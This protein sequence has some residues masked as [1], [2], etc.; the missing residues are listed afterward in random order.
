M[1]R[2]VVLIPAFL[3]LLAIGAGTDAQQGAPFNPHGN[4][5]TATNN[6]MA[7]HQPHAQN[8]S[9]EA[10][11]SSCHPVIQTHESQSCAACHD[12]HAQTTNAALVRLT[13]RGKPVVFDGKHFD[14]A[15]NAICETCHVTTRFHSP[16][17]TATHYEDQDCTK[18]HPHNSGFRPDP[19]SCT[20]CHGA[21]PASGA[22]L[23]HIAA[24]IDLQNCT[25]C[26][27]KVTNWRDAGH[28]NGRVELVDGGD[29][30]NTR[31]CDS[32]HG[33]AAGIA[34]A[35]N[36]WRA[37][38]HIA[39]CLGCHNSEKPGQL[40][41]RLAPAM[42]AFWLSNGHGR[43]ADQGLDLDCLTCHNLSAP[44]FD[45]T[46]NPRLI[47]PPDQ[48]CTSCHNDPARVGP[49]VSSHGNVGYDLS[50]QPP[51]SVACDTCHNPHGSANL[52]AVRSNLHG[53]SVVFRAFSGD[54]SFD[55]PDN[56]NSDDLCATCHTT[57]RHNRTPSNRAQLPHYEGTDCTTCHK[58]ETDGD[59]L[60]ADAF[61]PQGSCL[62]CHNQQQDNGDNLPPGGRRAVGADFSQRSHHIQGDA[63]DQQCLVCHD[64]ST[65]GD[66]TID[67]RMPDG[68][69][70][71]RFVSSDQVDLSPFCQACHD[72]DGSQ[73]A[74]VPGA[75]AQDPFGDG[76]NL[77]AL[78]PI[79]P[80]S[81]RDFAAAEEAS[82]G[83]ACNTCHTGHGSANLALIQARINGN[84]INFISHTGANSFDDANKADAND[85]CATCHVGVASK[86][87]GGDHRPSGDLDL[88][89]TDCTTCHRHD[90]DN[91]LAT[92]DG[93]MPSCKAC[94]GTPPPPAGNS[95]YHLN[96]ALT[97]HQ[98]HAGEY[99]MECSTCHDR[100][101]PA[102]SGHDTQPASF[103]DVFFSALNPLG[104]YDR[105][106]RTCANV[107]C[108]SNGQPDDAPWQVQTPVW[109]ENSRLS[110]AGCHQD[111]FSLDTGSHAEHLLPQYRDRGANAIGCYECHADT[112]QNGHNDAI[113][114]PA[115]HDNF[116]KDVRLDVS[117][118]WQSSLIGA[119]N[120][121]DKTCANS[122]CHSDGAASR[123]TPAAPVFSKPQWGDAR[124]GAC[125]SC[126][127]YSPTELKTG[128]HAR[129]FDFSD[130][131]PGIAVCE[132]CHTSVGSPNHV[133][134]R[135]DFADGKTL[136][137]TQVCDT[138][139][140]PGGAVNGVADA[141]HNWVSDSPVRC[142]GC[143]DS[144]PSRIKGVAAPDVVGDG[145]SYGFANSG[146]GREGIT[147]SCPVCHL[148]TPESNHFDGLAASYDAE[149]DNYQATRWL[150]IN[151]DVPIALGTGYQRQ[152]FGL[153]YACHSEARLVG[154]ASD[155]SNALFT[156]SAPPPA[157]YPLPVDAVTTG[158][159]NERTEGFNFGNAPA[160]IHWDHL[161]M[162][163]LTWDSDGDG[164]ADSKPTCVA[165]HDPHGVRS[166]AAGINYPAMTIADI[167]I[168][169]GQDATGS[170]GEVS[171]TAY[172]QRCNSCHAAA[173]IRYY[174]PD[175]P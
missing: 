27:P 64:Q 118:L 56:Q 29:L 153:C 125:G 6:C 148:K 116:V 52:D 18:C 113:A 159:R 10:A 115:K 85:L 108:H 132:T 106:T 160:N 99:G 110:C 2:F 168:V 151:L 74:F 40:N 15:D 101:D 111:Q 136:S 80:H 36:A 28:R 23:R 158:F 43:G 42:D 90:A 96:E 155:Y 49:D 144:Q 16:S 61:M 145:A 162:N 8:T 68:G 76:A 37:G 142:E 69:S 79:S 39:D 161:D 147:L 109:D 48:L 55:E 140:S 152:Q 75:G 107:G 89:G 166:F 128:A 122:L 170:Y 164:V 130:Q 4:Y 51:F 87:A 97:P 70:S 65:H 83:T 21:P 26:H 175:A 84:A 3:L 47:A 33:N 57:T 46:G 93:F 25:N 169:H 135:V 173:G 94:H 157:G 30:N 163:Q 54:N 143:H 59:P 154:L 20:V 141:R 82:F 120:P 172:N 66:G 31:V 44:H 24:D 45:Q 126:H 77:S 81:N 72:A 62:D 121:T 127:A 117:D 165:C 38:D 86:H 63:S 58:H 11:C 71:L 78:S 139:H 98:K 138:C 174:R 92:Q 123:E 102:Y 114:H 19:Q 7:C 5:S 95:S 104:S 32:C 60:T 131:G 1:K 9:P 34:A 88:R 100:L 13:V 103:Q 41:G 105:N 67:L 133:N 14:G 171:N 119:F 167:G 134:G 91:N 73:T 112:A 150:G 124:S 137:Q 149:K 17:A 12:P 53:S 129:H 156:H 146:H 50:T 22:H 35:K